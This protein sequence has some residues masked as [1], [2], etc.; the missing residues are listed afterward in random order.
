MIW[1]NQKLIGK[2]ENLIPLINASLKVE[3]AHYIENI[4]IAH[5]LIKNHSDAMYSL[6]NQSAYVFHNKTD[7][8]MINPLSTMILDV[9]TIEKNKFELHFEVLNALSAPSSHPIVCIQVSPKT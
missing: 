6:R 8:I 4:T 9:R 2:V 7:L 5:M 1:F 3:T